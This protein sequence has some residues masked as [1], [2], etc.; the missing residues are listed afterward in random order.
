MEE[1]MA[2]LMMVMI[3]VITMAVEELIMTM[4][5]EMVEK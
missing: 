4:K 5:G 1:K 2:K 3:V